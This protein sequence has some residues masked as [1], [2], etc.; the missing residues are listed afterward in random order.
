MKS[1]TKISKQAFKKTN[2]KL[3]ETILACKKNK[4]WLKIAS[5]ISGPKKNR[6]NIN[7]EEISKNI[8]NGKKIIIPGKIL[9]QGD[10]NKK[11]EI[12]ALS[13][14]E[15]AKEKLNKAGIK[16]SNIIEEIKKNPDAKDVEILT[17]K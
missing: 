1:K 9:S 17:K 5:I 16:F 12:I 3:V 14:S 8:K 2:P 10:L 13:F 4:D 15:K 7:L 6:I 11:V